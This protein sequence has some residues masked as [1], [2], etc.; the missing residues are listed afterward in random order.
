VGENK[1][2]NGILDSLKTVTNT[3]RITKALS[4]QPD[5]DLGAVVQDQL[6]DSTKIET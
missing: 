4:G 5:I 3:I 1:M 6:N 2:I